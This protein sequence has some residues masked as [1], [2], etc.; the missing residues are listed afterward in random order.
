VRLAS[1]DKKCVRHTIAEL[2]SAGQAGAANP[3]WFVVRPSDAE[4]RSAGQTRASA[5]TWF[6][7]LTALRQAFTDF[8]GEGARA[9]QSLTAIG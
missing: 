5:P 9:T 6:G 8:A 7:M 1:T 4:L 3:L 2:R